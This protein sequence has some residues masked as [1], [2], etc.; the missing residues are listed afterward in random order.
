MSGKNATDETGEPD[1]LQVDL[2]VVNRKLN[3][4]TGNLRLLESKLSYE[5]KHSIRGRLR[6]ILPLLSS[7]KELID[8]LQHHLSSINWVTDV[9]SSY[10]CGSLTINYEFPKIRKGE[11]LKTFEVLTL[12]DLRGYALDSTCHNM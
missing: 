2:E 11:I 7:K 3:T 4:E 12:N 6:I 8:S 9:Q 1:H 5:I 10:R